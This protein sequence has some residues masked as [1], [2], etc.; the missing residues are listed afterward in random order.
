MAPG[1]R[2]AIIAATSSTVDALSSAWLA[3][4]WAG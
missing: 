4:N 2:P 1:V 3:P